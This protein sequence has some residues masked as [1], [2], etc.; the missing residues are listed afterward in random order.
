MVASTLLFSRL[1]RST[2]MVPVVLVK[3]LVNS[4]AHGGR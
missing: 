4:T 1:A 3:A 2:V